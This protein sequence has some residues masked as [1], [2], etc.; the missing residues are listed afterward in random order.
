MRM[1]LNLSLATIAIAIGFSPLLLC[2]PTWA[3]EESS[4]P[5]NRAADLLDPQ[6]QELEDPFYGSGG[7]P[8]QFNPLDLIHRA[9][10]GGLRSMEEFIIEQDQNLNDAATDFRARQLQLLRQQQQAT[11]VEE[12]ASEDS[13]VSTPE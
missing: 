2:Q 13:A 6:I 3:D 1:K 9:N 11:P 5:T 4:E 7:D 10:L 12:G 8:E